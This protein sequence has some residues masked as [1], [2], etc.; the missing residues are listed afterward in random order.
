MLNI[1]NNWRYLIKA[2]GK[3]NKILIYWKE[4]EEKPNNNNLDIISEAPD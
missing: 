2:I 3:N 1:R 4:N